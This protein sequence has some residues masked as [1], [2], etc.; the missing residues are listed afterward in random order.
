MLTACGYFMVYVLHPLD[1]RWLLATTLDRLLLQ[2]WPAIV[3]LCFLVA[4]VP[5]RESPN[6][7]PVAALPL[8]QSGP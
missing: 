2:L 8:N 5:E 1:L 3:F 6:H 7:Q 4:R